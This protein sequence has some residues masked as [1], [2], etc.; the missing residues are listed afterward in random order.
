MI[1]HTTI[2][3]WMVPVCRTRHRVFAQKGRASVAQNQGAIQ[4]EID[5][6][7]GAH[8]RQLIVRHRIVVHAKEYAVR[9][10]PQYAASVVQRGRLGGKAW[11]KSTNTFHFK[12]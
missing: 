4:A 11:P 2:I 12:G 3:W 6:G 1:K 5:A 8:T 9:A 10:A 7:N